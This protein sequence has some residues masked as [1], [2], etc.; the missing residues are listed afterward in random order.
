MSSD[1][2]AEDSLPLPMSPELAQRLLHALATDDSVR[3]AFQADPASVLVQF[4]YP[5]ADSPLANARLQ[6]LVDRIAVKKLADK[7][8]IAKASAEIGASLTSRLKMLPIMLDA[9]DGSPLKCKD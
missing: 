4:G 5:L 7:Q 6:A 3:E 9:H 2:T 1:D 8:T